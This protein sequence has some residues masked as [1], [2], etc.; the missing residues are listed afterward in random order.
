MGRFVFF[1]INCPGAVHNSQVGELSRFFQNLK[2]IYD[3][4][5]ATIM[6]DLAFSSARYPFFIKSSESSQ[7]ITTED[8][9][10]A[11]E[12]T[13]MRQSAE[14]GLRCLQGSFLRLKEHFIY[15]ERGERAL[16]LRLVVLIYNYSVNTVGI[17]QIRNVYM[18]WLEEDSNTFFDL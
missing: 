4:F 14:W 10:L 8:Y 16:M 11:Y 12:A 18:P 7:A 6:V 5:N 17:N 15:E 13:S 9:L 3:T 2:N 1:C